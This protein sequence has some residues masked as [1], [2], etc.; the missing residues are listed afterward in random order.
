M[1]SFYP[2][3]SQTTELYDE[4]HK[5]ADSMLARGSILLPVVSAKPAVDKTMVTSF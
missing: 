5:T 4:N 1:M 2:D 3:S